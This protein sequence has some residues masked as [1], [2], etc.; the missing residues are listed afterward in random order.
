MQLKLGRCEDS[1]NHGILRGHKPTPDR[2]VEQHRLI[3]VVNET[4]RLLQPS[5]LPM[6]IRTELLT[7]MVQHR[8]YG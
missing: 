1:E 2:L 8:I 4:S 3:G 5:Q 7:P 6:E